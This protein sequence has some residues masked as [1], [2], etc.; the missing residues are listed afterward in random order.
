MRR[1]TNRALRVAIGW[2]VRLDREP[3]TLT[4][5]VKVVPSLLVSIANA[6]VFHPVV[7]P[8]SPA[9]LTTQ[10]PTCCAEPRSIC[11]LAAVASEHH[12]LLLARLPSTALAAASLAAHAADAVTLRPRARFVPSA[13]AGG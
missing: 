8:P 12:L 11:R 3:L 10:L 9:C 4:T 5:V 6:P 13:G 7:S 2:N 1:R